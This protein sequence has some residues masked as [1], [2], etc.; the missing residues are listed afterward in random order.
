MGAAADI[1]PLAAGT[2]EGRYYW[3]SA[4]AGGRITCRGCLVCFNG[5]K[6]CR[7]LSAMNRTSR[8]ELFVFAAL[9]TFGVLG[10]WAEPSWNFTPL[11]AVTALGAFYFR[12]WLPAVLLPSAVL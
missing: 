5:R 10:R 7:E 4:A 12:G 3:W 2:A 9:L 6:N 1:G 8:Q 11:A